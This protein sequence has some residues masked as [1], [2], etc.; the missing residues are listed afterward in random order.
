MH[1]KIEE[2]PEREKMLIRLK[3]LRLERGYS[4][5]G[6]AARKDFQCQ[7]RD[8]TFHNQASRKKA[9]R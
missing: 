9:I 7:P 8:R 6:Q 3:E 4:N 2:T 5:D 1:R